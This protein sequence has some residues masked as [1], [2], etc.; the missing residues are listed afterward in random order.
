MTPYTCHVVRAA[1]NALQSSAAYR[2]PP[3]NSVPLQP[4]MKAAPVVP[5]SSAPLNESLSKAQE[6]KGPPG[7]SK[8]KGGA[9]RGAVKAEER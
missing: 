6:G 4:S 9:R 2:M 3:E 1:S 8:S 5:V 7:R